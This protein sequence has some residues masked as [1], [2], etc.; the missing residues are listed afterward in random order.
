[1]EWD[2]V[3]GTCDLS[4]GYVD[5]VLGSWKGCG[6]GQRSSQSSNQCNDLLQTF[7]VLNLLLVLTCA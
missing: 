3:V 6:L 5:E 2:V 4:R 1:M 7:L